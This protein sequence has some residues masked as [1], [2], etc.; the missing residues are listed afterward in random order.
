MNSY[1]PWWREHYRYMPS[2][3]DA[4]GLFEERVSQLRLDREFDRVVVRYNGGCD[5]AVDV[6]YNDHT[7]PHFESSD[8]VKAHPDTYLAKYSW[9]KGYPVDDIDLNP[10]I[11]I[12]GRVGANIMS[13]VDPHL[14]D[15]NKYLDDLYNRIFRVFGKVKK[16][17]ILTGDDTTNVK[18][19]YMQASKR[20]RH[21]DRRTIEDYVQANPGETE[22]AILEI[23]KSKKT[24]TKRKADRFMAAADKFMHDATTKY[25]YGPHREK[26]LKEYEA[27]KR[28]L[29]KTPVKNFIE[30]ATSETINSGGMDTLSWVVFCNDYAVRKLYR[31]AWEIEMNGF[32]SLCSGVWPD[33]IST[34]EDFVVIAHQLLSRKNN[35][36]ALSFTHRYSGYRDITTSARKVYDV[37]CSVRVTYAG[38]KQ[39]DESGV[40]DIYEEYNDFVERALSG[41]QIGE[42][43]AGEYIADSLYLIMDRGKKLIR[44]MEML[45]KQYAISQ[46][47]TLRS[48]RSASLSA[49]VS[50]LDYEDSIENAVQLIMCSGTCIDDESGGDSKEVAFTKFRITDDNRDDGIGICLVLKQMKSYVGTIIVVDK[51]VRDGSHWRIKHNHH[52]VLYRTLREFPYGKQFEVEGIIFWNTVKTPMFIRQL[53]RALDVR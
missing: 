49:E 46:A 17:A 11:R 3:E 4:D 42:K 35:T 9:A 10:D 40:A 29:M 8:D 1:L 12:L 38:C 36:S 51:A 53:Q 24:L 7:V 34:I 6:W 27:M 28:E 14:R 30:V 22:D 5:W 31:I 13:E 25:L 26:I 44:K 19:L 47:A 16:L 43:P 18:E 21:L 32:S 39:P 15:Y 33:N 48:G 2:T 37:V 45:D 52:N 50:P 41:P 23:M 20:C